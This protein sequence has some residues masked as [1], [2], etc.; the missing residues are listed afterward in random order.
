MSIQGSPIAGSVAQAA[1]RAREAAVTNA[2]QTAERQHIRLRVEKTFESRLREIDE[3]EEAAARQEIDPDQR[4]E[5]QQ[6]QHD[7]QDAFEHTDAEDEA[8][9]LDESLDQTVISGGLEMTPRP[10]IAPASIVPGKYPSTALGGHAGP[11]QAPIKAASKKPVHGPGDP[12][13][14]DDDASPPSRLDLTV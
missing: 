3:G 5:Q 12:A 9:L 2:S 8:A 11:P 6:D 7:R 13:K 10:P 1:A 4:R 14:N